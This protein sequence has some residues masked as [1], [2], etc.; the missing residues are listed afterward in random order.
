MKALTFKLFK[1]NEICLVQCMEYDFMSQGKD[2][3]Q[4]IYRMFKTIQAHIYFCKQD[5][6]KPFANVKPAPK[7]FR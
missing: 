3:K 4:A 5:G 1:E 2:F 6:K 7:Y